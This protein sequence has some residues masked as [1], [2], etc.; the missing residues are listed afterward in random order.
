VFLTDSNPNVPKATPLPQF[1]RKSSLRQQQ[2]QTTSLYRKAKTVAP[3]P[4][5][6]VTAIVGRKSNE[7]NVALR[8]FDS[9]Q[10][11]SK[12]FTIP[13]P[14]GAGEMTLMSYVKKD[15]VW[16]V[17]LIWSDRMDGSRLNVS[18]AVF[19]EENGN[20]DCQKVSKCK[21]QFELESKIA[22]DLGEWRSRL[23]W[24]EGRCVLVLMKRDLSSS[25][26]WLRVKCFDV[27]HE[28]QS[29]CVSEMAIDLGEY[30]KQLKSDEIDE[31]DVVVK[32]NRSFGCDDGR[33]LIALGFGSGVNE[34]VLMSLKIK[35]SDDDGRFVDIDLEKSF[36]CECDD[37][38]DGRRF[39]CLAYGMR[40]IL[41]FDAEAKMFIVGKNEDQVD[42]GEQVRIGINLVPL[43]DAL[44]RNVVWKSLKQIVA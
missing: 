12:N 10:F 32:I 7:W 16:R 27:T 22:M 25:G 3:L 20:I 43:R 6:D 11:A 26:G 17:Y 14:I 33:V 41:G 18:E 30:C 1:H 38:D 8:S 42:V 36:V 5:R 21:W 19:N 31:S 34:Y 2:H 29:N 28:N 39:G 15:G 35:M 23:V 24:L 13:N 9:K 4:F 37:D 40:E 44:K